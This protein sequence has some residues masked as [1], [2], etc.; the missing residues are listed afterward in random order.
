MSRPPITHAVFDLD[1][2][3]LDSEH[4]YTD[5]AKLVCARYQA[6]YTVAL[7]RA[8]MGGDTLRGAEI[9]VRELGLP[10]TPA[11]YV[12]QREGELHRM[13]EDVAVMPGAAALIEALRARGIPIAIATSGHRKITEHKLAK[14]AFLRSADVLVC[15]DDPRLKNPK[16]APDIFLLA[17]QDLGA[18][19]ARCLA[20]EDSVNGLRAALAAGMRTVALVD[21]RWGFEASDFADAE[22]VVA[23][24]DE[25]ALH[26][27]C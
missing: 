22:Q 13:F 7:K 3:L 20:V 12:A 8:C 1:G 24:L 9:V 4:L 16:P 23:A 27:F 21:P 18:A 17:A 26:A 14:H 25:L 6:E 15:G 5:A 11:E 19:P 2:T 10:I